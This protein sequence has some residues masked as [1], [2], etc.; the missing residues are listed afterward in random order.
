[1]RKYL[2]PAIYAPARLCY[3]KC[4]AALSLHTGCVSH[5]SSP[6]AAECYPPSL[7]AGG[8]FLFRS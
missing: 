2:P 8:I 6:P 3:S 1:M 4:D 5:F 7:P